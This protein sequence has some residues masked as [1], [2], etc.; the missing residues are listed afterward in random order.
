MRNFT[1]KWGVRLT[2]R[3]KSHIPPMSTQ[4]KP[5]GW[6]YPSGSSII[7]GY[8]TSPLFREDCL[9]RIRQ[10]QLEVE[11]DMRVL[12]RMKEEHAATENRLR[13]HKKEFGWI[14]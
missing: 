5:R 10:M 13:Q 3:V 12:A 6:Y 14:D 11:A 1:L 4:P 9:E 8:D 2:T 7:R